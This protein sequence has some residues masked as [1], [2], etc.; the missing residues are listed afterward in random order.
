M[1]ANVSAMGAYRFDALH[2]RLGDLLAFVVGVAH[3]VAGKPAFTANFA[4]TCHES[5][6]PYVKMIAKRGL[7]YHKNTL[8]ARK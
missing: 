6:P 5:N 4:F 8:F 7:T 3:F 1:D 2:I